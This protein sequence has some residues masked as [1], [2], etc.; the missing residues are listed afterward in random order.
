MQC[1]CVSFPCKEYIFKK[2]TAP[3][4][5]SKSTLHYI[6]ERGVNLFDWQGSSAELTPI[7]EVWTIM[8]KK[9]GK[10]PNYKIKALE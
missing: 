4:N 7:E 3:W 1:E 9:C 2:N 5:W 6:T 8:K 10:L